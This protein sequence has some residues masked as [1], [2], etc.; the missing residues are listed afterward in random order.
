VG[1][2]GRVRKLLLTHFWP[3]SDRT[4]AVSSAYAEFSGD[5]AAATEGMA[6]RC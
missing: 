1:Q 5:I 2:P 6:L 4:A 3:G